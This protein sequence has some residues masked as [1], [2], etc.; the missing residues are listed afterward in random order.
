M[1]SD[2]KYD[3]MPKISLTLAKS[4]NISANNSHGNLKSPAEISKI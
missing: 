4:D 3:S 2:E 1:M